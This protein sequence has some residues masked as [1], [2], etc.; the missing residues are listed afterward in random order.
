M[1]SVLVFETHPIQYRTPVYQELNRIL[2]GAFEVVFASDFSVSG[3]RDR[4][5]G[6]VFSWDSELLQGYP[7]RILD[8]ANEDGIATWSG[9]S[10][11]GIKPLLKGLKP[12]A[13]VMSSFGYQ[14]SAAV[15]WNARRNRV[16]IWVR[17]ET[18]DDAVERSML[19][20]RLRSFLYRS[21]YRNIELFF[22]IGRANRNHYLQ[23]GVPE[24]KLRTA[25]YCT[26]DHFDSVSKD[27]MTTRRMEK[28]REL[29]IGQNAFVVGFF[30]KLITKKHPQILLD[31]YLQLSE[32]LRSR[33]HLLFVGSGELESSLKER[34]NEEQ[35]PATFAGF[36]NQ[37][38]LADYYLATDT[39]VLPSRRM[40]ETWGLV[41][42]EALQCGCSVVTS[43]AVG[44]RYDFKDLERFR[45]FPVEDSSALSLHFVEL[46]QLPR[47]FFWARP[48][49]SQ[50]SIKAAAGAIA[51]EIESL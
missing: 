16:P 44:C 14:F 25:H 10:G 23:H 26:L 31:A 47:D 21:L 43:D 13:V 1:R 4:D 30:G 32:T 20:S 39:I 40:G 11:K 22:C 18:Q 37:S 34:C 41:V 28:R 27:E 33:I 42:N 51:A 12:K 36:V 17:M 19:K 46:M 5:F 8:N 50:Y 24:Y 9:I 3:Y 49:M 2:P 29:G 6:I 45:V 38:E 15:Y 7:Y 35:I 48:R